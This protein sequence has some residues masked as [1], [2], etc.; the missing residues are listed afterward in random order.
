MLIKDLFQKD[1]ARHLNGVIKADQLDESSVWQEL[2]EFVVT[3]ELDRHLHRFFGNY[4][5]A[6]DRSGDPDVAGNIGV[7]VSGFFGSGKS[8]FI[9]VLSY[10]L[11]ND[12][13]SFEG[14]AREAVSFFDSK[15]TD[16]MLLGEIKRAAA[17]NTDVILFN[18]DSKADRGK[19]G[20][21][22]LQVFL[23]VLNELAGY[24]SDYP[25]L[26]HIER[27]LDEQGMLEAFHSAYRDQAKAEW[28][29]ERD[30]WM[31]NR[32]KVM[33]ALV[34][35]TG[36]SAADCEKWIDGAREQFPLTI[37]NFSKWV[38]EFIDRKGPSHRII[39]LVDEVG[40][41]I[42]TDTQLMLSLQ[43]ITE[44]LGTAC[45]GR[46]WIVVTSQEDIDAVLGDTERS[47]ANDFSKIQGRFRTRLSLSSANVDEVIQK[48]LL[49]KKPGVLSRLE[50]EYREKGDILKNQLSFRDVGMTLEQYSSADDYVRNYP[51]APYQFKLLQKIFEAIRKA[52][53]TGLHLAQGERSLLD[54]FQQAIQSYS[55]REVGILV[56]LYQF[57]PA[58]EN[59]LDTAVKRTIEYSTQNPALEPFDAKLLQVLFLIRYVD[60]VKGNVDNLTTL[61][62]YEVDAPR[63]ELRRKVEAG[64][65]RLEAQTLVNRSDDVY[66]YL[67]SEEQDINRE[68]NRIDIDS[69]DM[70]RSLGALIFEDV[71]EDNKRHR[72]RLNKV[73]FPFNRISDGHPYRSRSEGA[74]VVSVITPLSDGYEAYLDPA[75]CVFESMREYGQ[76]IIRLR[77]DDAFEG[78]LSKYLRTDKYLRTKDDGTLSQTTLRI[79]QDLADQNRRRRK[80]IVSQLSETITNAEYFVDGASLATNSQDPKRAVEEAL[81]YLIRNTYSKMEYLDQYQPDP[82]AEAVKV[83]RQYASRQSGLAL[84]ADGSNKRAL[85]DLGDHIRLSSEANHRVVL[86]DLVDSRFK[87]PYG[88]PDWEV[89]LLLSRLVAKGEVQFIEAGEAIAKERLADTLTSRSKWKNIVVRSRKAIALDLAKK[90]KHLG[91]RLF[92]EMGPED[93]EELLDFLRDHLVRWRSALTRFQELQRVGNY[94]GGKEITAAMRTLERVLRGT[95]GSAFFQQFIGAEQELQEAMEATN[96]LRH[97]HEH[98]RPLWERLCA[99]LQEFSHNELELGEHE[100]AGSSLQR[101]KEIR[102]A[103]RPHAMIKE[104]DTLISTVQQVNVRFLK[105]RREAAQ[106]RIDEAREAIHREL[107]LASANAQLQSYSLAPLQRLSQRV[108]SSTSLAHIAQIEAEAEPCKSAAFEQIAEFVQTIDGPKP[109]PRRVVRPATL[110]K[111]ELLESQAD[112]DAFLGVLRNK[113]M[114]A[115]ACNER[116]EIG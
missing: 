111:S 41:F 35:A 14:Q 43:T 90:A 42:G 86:H 115:I 65:R 92:H 27:G 107:K 55:D 82:R 93:A 71:L 12:V 47:R 20:D 77:E 88:W 68:I 9:K 25:Y 95:G 61:C 44:E 36:Q 54:A 74:L 80:R 37:E 69:S 75:R 62:M 108:S 24:S 66:Y 84:N 16:H 53:A 4:T 10:L 50:A 96:D 19:G 85:E 6:L 48:R 97:F 18:I 23:K 81:E 21:A 39:F 67:T 87:R 2:E 94:P 7:W 98:Q 58:I 72:Y 17:S 106:E 11:K 101:L 13:H 114:D 34:E 116:I 110:V 22:L 113:L 26:A 46:A 15:I 103:A 79:H 33:K 70:A 56:T 112:V 51:V 78:E 29:Q 64:L 109:K 45:G 59:F 99:T 105:E 60:E 89:I 104:V 40:Q 57:Y 31:F 49:A 63:L 30:F 32:D 28:T 91:Q 8:H 38:R 100:E 102:S 52:G 5:D 76:I 3:L 1:I 73:D 83:L